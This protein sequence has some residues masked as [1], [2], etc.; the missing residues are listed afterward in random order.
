MSL[1]GLQVDL[2]ARSLSQCFHHTFPMD[3][4]RKSRPHGRNEVVLVQLLGFSL[5]LLKGRLRVLFKQI[6]VVFWPMSHSSLQLR[7]C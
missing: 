7:S 6:G 1:K 4:V 3:I 2:L 5:C